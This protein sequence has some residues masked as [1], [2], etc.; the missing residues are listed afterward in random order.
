[1]TGRI[2]RE[3][4]TVLVLLLAA[5][6]LLAVWM[7]YWR[8]G[9]YL[10]GLALLVGALLRLLLPTRRAGLLVVRGRRT[11]IAVLTALGTA[12][13]VLARVVPYVPPAG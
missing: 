6:G 10:V 9:L 13:L 3:A 12:V 4:P 8:K 11:D 2:A 7:H 1:M 5:A